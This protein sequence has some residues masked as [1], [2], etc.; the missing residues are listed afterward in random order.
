MQDLTIGRLARA[1][2]VGV[3]TIR[4]Y[5]QRGLLPVPESRGAFRHYPPQVV[6]RIGFI[7]RAQELGFSLGEIAELLRL[8]DGSERGSIRRVAADRLAQIETKLADL[9]RMQRALRHLVDA[10]EHTGLEQPCPI[11]ATLAR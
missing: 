11:I 10:C 9:R 5:Q 4:Y 3:E 8:E 2:G 7:K 6:Q 1:A